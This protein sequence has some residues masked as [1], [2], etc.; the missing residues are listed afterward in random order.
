MVTCAR[1]AIEFYTDANNEARYETAEMA[2][3]S[4]LKLLDAWLGHPHISIL[5]NKVYNFE[6]KINRAIDT[7]EKNIGEPNPINYYKKFLL[8]QT[9]PYDFDGSNIRVETFQIT[10]TFLICDSEKMQE[11]F[12]RKIG[13]ND[14]FNYQQESRSWHNEDHCL[15]KR[16]QISA[17][18]YVDILEQSQCPKRQVIKKIRQC[19]IYDE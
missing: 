9:G 13:S 7:I 11:K 18:D 6:E 8:N 12:I 2:I 1:G 19:F 17:R 16:K 5:D 15:V 3:A 10:E 4:D 14:V